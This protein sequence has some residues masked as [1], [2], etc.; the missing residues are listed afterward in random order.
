MR[1]P[2]L[3][4]PGFFHPRLDGV[5]RVSGALA[6]ALERLTQQ[7]PYVLA[8]NDPAGA[9][10]PEAGRGFGR[11]Y[12]AMFRAAVCGTPAPGGPPE[13]DS[14]HEPPV[15]CSHLGLSP[16]ARVMARRLRRP[17]VVFVHGV[18][19]WKPL[20]FRQR[21]GV[22]GAARLLFNSHYTRRRF[23]ACNPW[24]ARLPG[25]V[26]PL[27][28]PVPAL[29]PPTGGA[30]AA[31][32]VARILSVG[33]MAR[34]EVYEA[35]RD[36]ADLYKGFRSVVEAVGLLREEGV[37]AELELV[38]DGNARADLEAW[39]RTLRVSPHVCFLGRIPDDALVRRYAAARVFV[40]ASEGEGFG[41]VFA[42][43]M[44]YG[45]PCLGVAAG[46]APEVIENDVSGY[47]VRPRDSRELADRLHVLLANEAVHDRLSAGA[48]AR[49]AA[50][51]REEAFIARLEAALR[52]DAT[53]GRAP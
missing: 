12:A 35:H 34:E 47:V 48:R 16:V 19:A 27:G 17:Y 29:A 36:P 43:A 51:F 21:W 44:A 10:P 26:V 46:A 11:R 39:V 18:E 42:E 2:L 30:R 32:G 3:I 38:G 22:A 6:T 7:R 31:D 13:A 20:R 52:S 37:P 24:A 23:V 8:A 9:C 14:G 28:V 5:G 50:H 33:R 49:Y 45:L 25:V 41:L 4:C 40:L 53:E 1:R 15:V